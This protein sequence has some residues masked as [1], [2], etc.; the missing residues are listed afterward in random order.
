MTIKEE[1]RVWPEIELELL[2][3]YKVSKERYETLN[4][5][6]KPL[7]VKYRRIIK[8]KRA[9]NMTLSCQQEKKKE[10]RL[11]QSKALDAEDQY[12]ITHV[13]SH[14][15]LNNEEIEIKY[16]EENKKKQRKER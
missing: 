14:G 13:K 11:Q 3:S 16:C 2:G 15:T 9:E 12:Q 1:R 8:G 5:T 7:K 10:R 4:I 6:A